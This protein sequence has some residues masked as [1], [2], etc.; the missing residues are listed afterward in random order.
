MSRCRIASRIGNWYIRKRLLM[1]RILPRIARAK[2]W[3]LMVCITAGIL[4]GVVS[5]VSATEYPLTV[6]DGLG[7]TV[8]LEKAPQRIISL[9][10]SVTENLFALGLDD[11][12]VG[13]S[14]YSNYPAAAQSKPVIGDA[15]HLSY[16]KVIALEPDLVVGDA[17]LVPKYL[18]KLEE[19]GVTVLAI[20]PTSLA[21]V[22]EAMLLLGRVTD[23]ETEARAVVKEMQDKIHRVETALSGL[24]PE[25]KPLVFVEV[26]DDPLMTCG[27]GSFMQELIQR[28]GGRNL[29]ADA[30]GAWVQYSSELVVERDP[31]I[32][33]LT[34][35]YKDK[36]KARTAWRD[37]KAVKNDRIIVIDSD[38]FVRT[39][40]RLAG[41]LLQLAEIIHPERFK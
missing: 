25:E 33:I 9:T 40:P 21:E 23:R 36:V 11:Q 22:M 14:S 30:D 20:N 19:L 28:A 4:A 41:A 27:P 6:V 12:I 2:V 31:D 16:E 26:W 37:I 10:P 39:T 18:E 38:P 34:R 24:T 17:Q 5:A 13:V 8:R 1:R 29:A 15:L 3:L 7:R 32:I 35:A